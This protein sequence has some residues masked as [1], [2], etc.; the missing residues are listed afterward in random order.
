MRTD[1]NTLKSN[2]L[3]HKISPL[4]LVLWI[5]FISG[6]N[7]FDRNYL[8]EAID[9]PFSVELC[10][11]IYSDNSDTIC[12]CIYT[13]TLIDEL[14]KRM[15]SED[16]N[17]FIYKHLKDSL[18]ILVSDSFFLDKKRFE[19]RKDSSVLSIYEKNGVN[20]LLKKYFKY[21]DGSYILWESEEMFPVGGMNPKPEYGKKH[22]QSIDYIIYLLSKHNIYIS[23]FWVSDGSYTI[24]RINKSLSDMSNINQYP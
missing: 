6:C 19:I 24:M 9:Y 11:L 20:G 13:E 12:I 21:E 7:L 22:K 23:S 15:K 18:P 8:K 2:R 16:I 10:P 4:A 14:S 1:P 17:P 5:T 3:F